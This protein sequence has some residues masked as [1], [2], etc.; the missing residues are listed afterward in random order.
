MPPFPVVRADGNQCASSLFSAM[1]E[2]NAV[3]RVVL[4]FGRRPAHGAMPA[5]EPH[6]FGNV[7]D[8]L[9]NQETSM[10]RGL[11]KTAIIAWISQKL[12]ERL[13]REKANRALA[14]HKRVA[15]HRRSLPTNRGRARA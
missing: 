3:D 7:I 5:R 12:I 6:C 8:R 15:A 10:I 2:P 4:A 1:K 13:T 9:L 11:I 14:T